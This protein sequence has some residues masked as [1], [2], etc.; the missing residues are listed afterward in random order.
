MRPAIKSNRQEYWECVQ[1][2]CDNTL[3]ISE[4]G[5]N[6]LHNEIGKYFKLKEESIEPPTIYLGIK[7][8]QVTWE[9]GAYAWLFSSS[10][11]LQNA[12]KNVKEYLQSKGGKL[13]AKAC[14]VL[15][16]NYWHD[17]DTCPELVSDDASYFLS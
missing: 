9:K 15:S 14:T 1:L 16:M 6:I 10:Q 2:Y 13:L 12:V 11:Y 8:I 5:E 4:N 3:I 17:I 7:L